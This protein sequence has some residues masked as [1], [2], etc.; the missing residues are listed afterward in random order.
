MTHLIQID[1][2]K[3]L[4]NIYTHRLVVK[5]LLLLLLVVVLRLLQ[6]LL[7]FSTCVSEEVSKCIIFVAQHA[8]D[9]VIAILNYVVKTYIFCCCKINCVIVDG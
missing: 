4:L 7:L 1:L 9:A 2:I 6:L 8:R 3:R 5:P